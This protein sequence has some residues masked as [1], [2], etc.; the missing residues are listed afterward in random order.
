[1]SKVKQSKKSAVVD[2]STE[3]L[4]LVPKARNFHCHMY[5]DK[6]KKVSKKLRLKELAEK[7]TGNT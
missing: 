3:M 4:L 6:S 7:K 1:M 5:L 2:N